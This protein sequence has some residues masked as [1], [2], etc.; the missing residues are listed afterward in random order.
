V[1]YALGAPRE[2]ICPLVVV[3]YYFYKEINLHM[4][5]T[6]YISYHNRLMYEHHYD[7]KAEIFFVL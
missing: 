6:P 7:A 2:N 4:K 5:M 1:R 3:D